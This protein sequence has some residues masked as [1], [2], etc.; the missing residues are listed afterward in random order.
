MTKTLLVGGGGRE[1]AICRRLIHSGSV[2]YAALGHEN[3]SI[4][5]N[6]TK[7]ILVKETDHQTILK[8]ALENRIELAFIGPDPV[9]ATPLADKL[10]G[11]GIPVASP[12]RLA[13]RIETNKVFMR[14]LLARWKIPGS[15]IYLS[16]STERELEKASEILSGEFVVKPVGLTGGKGVRVM[17][18]HFSTRNEGFSY[19][20]DLLGRDGAVLLEDK[21]VGEEFSLQ[22]F[23]DGK[24]VIPMPLAQ[25]YK[26]ALEGDLGPNTG[27]M[28]SITDRDHLLPF[29]TPSQ[30]EEALE[31]MRKVETAMDGEGYPF[32]GVMYGQFMVTRN[33]LRLIE[34]NARFADPEGINVLSILEDDLTEILLKVTEGSLGSRITFKKEATVLKYLVPVGYGSD[35]QPGELSIKQ[36]SQKG[37]DIYYASVSGTLDRVK[38]SSS[39]AIAV[40]AS[41]ESIP[42]AGD[43]VDRALSRITGSY[44]V[45]KDIGTKSLLQKKIETVSRF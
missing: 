35:P 15:P 44:Y 13:A 18:D 45:R 34:I 42:E 26:R 14:D 16:V 2:V 43:N 20:R 3:P 32:H 36:S 9:L 17:G 41:G 6:S 37:S 10:R 28:G 40:I 22:A 30:R 1:D 5:K 8:F 33:G 23:C 31:I 24:N 4:L 11:K 12:S 25:D 21:L 39:R 19:A 29:V 7:H 27:G 38:M